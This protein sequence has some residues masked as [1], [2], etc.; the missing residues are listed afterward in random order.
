[1]QI[2]KRPYKVTLSPS[3]YEQI[4]AQ[5]FHIISSTNPDEGDL[6]TTGKALT[7]FKGGLRASLTV[8]YILFG[9]LTPPASCFYRINALSLH[10]VPV[11]GLLSVILRLLEELFCCCRMPSAPCSVIDPNEA[12]IVSEGK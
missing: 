3:R 12:E 9:W 5:I 10:T 11:W 8:A 2:R 1:L 4:S 6:T 7:G